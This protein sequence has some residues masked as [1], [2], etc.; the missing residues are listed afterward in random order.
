M[1]VGQVAG[2]T[3]VL[4][5]RERLVPPEFRLLS[6][7]LHSLIGICSSDRQP[8]DPRVYDTLEA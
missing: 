5:P 1:A 8:H 4:S 2:R 7:T 6:K 3:V